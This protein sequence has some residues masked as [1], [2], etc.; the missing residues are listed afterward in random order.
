[1]HTLLFSNYGSCGNSEAI[2]LPMRDPSIVSKLLRINSGATNYPLFAPW[3]GISSFK[4][5]PDTLKVAVGPS[6]K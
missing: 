4:T 3:F 1:V 2:S 5:I 6:G